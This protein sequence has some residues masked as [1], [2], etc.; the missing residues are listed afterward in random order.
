MSTTARFRRHARG[1]PMRCRRRARGRSTRSTTRRRARTCM[2]QR[3][4][5]TV[6]LRSRCAPDV[7]S[8]RP[9]GDRRLGFRPTGSDRCAITPVNHPASKR[10]LPP[11]ATDATVNQDFAHE[12][13]AWLDRHVNLETGVGVPASTT[14]A[15][16]P[17]RERIDALLAYLG[18]PQLEYPR[19]ASHRDERQDVDGTHGHATPCRRWPHGRFVHEPPPRTGERAHRVPRRADRR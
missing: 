2:L 18:S 5:R 8:V 14:R 17:T 19:R 12:A 9:P 13:R 1:R 4:P 7:A 6:D 10:F 3:F 11:N 15:T 16:A